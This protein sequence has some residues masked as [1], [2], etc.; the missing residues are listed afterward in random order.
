MKNLCLKRQKIFSDHYLPN[1]SA[2][3]NVELQDAARS[4]GIN[5]FW[6]AITDAGQGLIIRLSQRFFFGNDIYI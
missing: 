1:Y 3:E 2:Q 5:N 6:V 4:V